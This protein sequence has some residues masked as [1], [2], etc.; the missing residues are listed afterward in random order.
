MKTVEQMAEPLLRKLDEWETGRK[1]IVGIEGY[2]ATGKTTLLNYVGALRPEVLALEVDDFLA[3]AREREAVTVPWLEPDWR[4]A[5]WFRYRILEELLMQYEES[6]LPYSSPVYNRKSKEFDGKKVF[7]LS[8]ATM[9]AEGTFLLQSPLAN[10][11]DYLVYVDLPFDIADRRRWERHMQKEP[12]ADRVKHLAWVEEFIKLYSEYL[13]TQ[14]PH[15][16]ADLVIH[17]I[18]NQP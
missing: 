10:R 1:T 11:L 15:K 5:P 9:V 12:N 14:E 17:G 2:S 4:K 18:D 6:D 16:R 8:R 7:D 13:E 3:P